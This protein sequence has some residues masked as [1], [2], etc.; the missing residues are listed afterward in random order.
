MSHLT[1]LFAL[2]AMIPA[3]SNAPVPH[4]GES[5]TIV[6]ALCQGGHIAIETGKGA[7]LPVGTSPCCAKGCRSSERR[8]K[9][10]PEQ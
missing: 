6:L 4:S 9:L 3:L 5:G 8:K 7:P 2:V 10:D 1:D